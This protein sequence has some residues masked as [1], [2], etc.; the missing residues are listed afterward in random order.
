MT[1]PPDPDPT[2]ARGASAGSDGGAG[3]TDLPGQCL[4]FTL[5]DEEYAVSILQVR[6]IVEF[7]GTSRVPM[8]PPWIRGVMNLRGTVVPVI[9]LAVKFGLPE[10]TVA[11]RTCVVVFDVE[12]DGELALMGVVVDTVKRVLDLEQATIE[13][14]PPFGTRVRVEYLLA[15]G[16][17]DGE[18]FLVLD[19]GRVLS[20]DELL[21]VA[22]VPEGAACG[23]QEETVD[24]TGKN[25]VDR[26]AAEAPAAS[27]SV[28]TP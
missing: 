21:A 22:A 23:L 12:L 26:P 17:L 9:D 1:K 13:E 14:P 5:A 28:D 4:T 16:R 7:Q 11:M 19:I 15:V 24:S 8:T 2:P 27:T 25:L 10:T 6:E 18:L 20:A 3:V